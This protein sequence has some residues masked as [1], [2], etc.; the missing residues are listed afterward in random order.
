MGKYSIIGPGYQGRSLNVNASR[1]IN[2]YPELNPQDSKSVGSLVGT[3]G[4][5]LYIDTL[6]G[7]IRGM[8]YFN[9]LIYFVSANK[10]YSVD[11]AKNI[12]PVLNN[13]GAHVTL[14]T[15]DGR[16]EMADNGI[17]GGAS[18]QLA[19]VDE[20]NIYC[21]N[22]TTKVL[23]SAAVPAKTIAFI[24]G[25]FM[26][27]MGDAKFGI[28]ALYDGSLPWAALAFSTA[29]AYPDNLQCVIN[30]HNEAWL[31]GEY[32]TE[33]WVPDGSSNP[34]PFSRM[35]VI[36][37]GTVAPHSVAKGNNTIFWLVSERNGTS[38]EIFGIGMANG[39]G[40]QIVTP[41]S[42]NYHF[43][44]YTKVM[45]AWGY[46]YTDRGHEFYVLTFPSE[47]ATWVYDATTNL[48]H[49][50]SRYTGDPYKINRHIGNAYA[51]AWGKH[52]IGS[53][54]DGKIYEMSEKYYS[55]NGDPIASVRISPPI[56]DILIPKML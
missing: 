47:N 24:S 41:Q 42:I 27:D 10:L 49:E 9:N 39:Y 50:R 36:D 33:I 28:S 20:Q 4:L 26:A 56:D 15:S 46:C 2:F 29:D 18:N 45:D 51:Y 5:L 8:H 52:F 25:Y 17:Y 53:F 7:P 21:I 23:T 3:P 1:C 14:S 43:S 44:K 40:V 19:F 38:G 16:V 32:S 34:L 6:L 54:L 35:T 30:N 12:F 13:I 48:C 37:Y 11:S 31:I 22:I 55:D